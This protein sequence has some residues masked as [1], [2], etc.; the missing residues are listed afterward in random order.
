V[1]PVKIEFGVRGIAASD[2]TLIGLGITNI[3]LYHDEFYTIPK[4]FVHPEHGYKVDVVVIPYAT[5]EGYTGNLRMYPINHCDF[6]DGY[7]L[8]VSDDVFILGYP[9]NL[10]GNYELPIWKRGSVATEPSLDLDALPMFL[11]DTA[12]R[13]GMS[14]SPV[15]MQRSGFHMKGKELNTN[16]LIGTIRTFVGVYSC[17]LGTSNQV[18]AQL[19][20]VWKPNVIEEIINGGVI[21][22]IDFQNK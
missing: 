2:E 7:N 8:A 5:V 19:G 16:D 18:E 1:F 15:I 12:T 13:P 17:R 10:T 11:I 22:S 14:G 3:D 6:V 21:G 9:L 20:I 4:W